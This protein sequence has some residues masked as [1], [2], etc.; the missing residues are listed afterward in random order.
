MLR[1][2]LWTSILT[3]DKYKSGMCWFNSGYT[4]FWRAQLLWISTRK[5]LWFFQNSQS[6]LLYK[7]KRFGG[8]GGNI[9]SEDSILVANNEKENSK[10]NLIYCGYGQ[11]GTLK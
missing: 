9:S 1:K 11:S 10:K 8:G 5:R 7:E 6:K 2:L 3:Y 4:R